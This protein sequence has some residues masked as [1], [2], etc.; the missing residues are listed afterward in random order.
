MEVLLL[1]PVVMLFANK[2]K[3]LGN[4]VGSCDGGLLAIPSG[5]VVC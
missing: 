3:C 1:F 4:H 5:H 2:H